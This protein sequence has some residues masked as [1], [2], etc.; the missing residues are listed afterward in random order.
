MDNAM[1][2]LITF[3]LVALPLLLA[4]EKPTQKI[5]IP[6]PD[7]PSGQQGGN[8]GNNG[9]NEGSGDNTMIRDNKPKVKETFCFVV[10]CLRENKPVYFHCAAG[11]DRTG[12]LAVL[13]EG[14]L[15]VSESDMAKDYELTYFSPEDWSMYKGEYQHI[16]STYSFQS[17]FKTIKNE[18]DSGTYQERIV[19]YLL[20]IGVPQKDIDDLRSIML[21]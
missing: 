19:K 10:Q 21:E 20:Q 5:V 2:R 17:I 15:G 14:A 16:I 4:C 3:F 12:T 18:T 11:R 7:K 13:L 8:N 6:I 1:K 9:G